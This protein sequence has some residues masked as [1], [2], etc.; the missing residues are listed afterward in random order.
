MCA[1]PCNL[2]L[3]WSNG[4][5][6]STTSSRLATIKAVEDAR[7]VG[8]VALDIRHAEAKRIVYGEG[9]QDS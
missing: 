4:R 9:Q 1:G 6:R 3:R 8:I 7:G 5:F 2:R